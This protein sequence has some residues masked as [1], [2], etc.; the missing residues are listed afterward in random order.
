MTILTQIEGDIL[1]AFIS[2]VFGSII[3]LLLQ[4]VS[5]FIGRT[6][7]YFKVTDL[8]EQLLK[9]KIKI[10]H[11]K[12]K[13]YH[14]NDIT[15]RIY[16][17]NGYLDL[18]QCDK[19]VIKHH[20]ITQQYTD[21]IKTFKYCYVVTD[22][23]ILEEKLNYYSKYKLNKDY[24]YYLIINNKDY[25]KLNVDLKEHPRYLKLSKLSRKERNVLDGPFK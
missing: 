21:D 1:I 12:K 25:Y 16:D 13:K 8:K 5:N 2:A 19:T 10:V 3:T 4:W 7:I 18:I 11:T 14:I 20:G 15:L 9:A 23:Y 17:D 6:K 24:D 22:E